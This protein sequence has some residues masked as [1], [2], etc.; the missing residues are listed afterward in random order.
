MEK[1]DYGKRNGMAKRNRK[2]GKTYRRGQILKATI[3]FLGAR[4]VT[5]RSCMKVELLGHYNGCKL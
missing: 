1:L 2:M 3:G 5:I 4:G